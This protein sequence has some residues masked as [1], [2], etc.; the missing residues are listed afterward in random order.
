MA[1]EQWR[2]VQALVVRYSLTLFLVWPTLLVTHSREEDNSASCYRLRRACHLGRRNCSTV[3]IST[4]FCGRSAVCLVRPPVKG[5]PQEL[6][7]SQN[8]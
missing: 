6:N 1:I 4:G 7:L 2:I 3:A 5:R 8:Q